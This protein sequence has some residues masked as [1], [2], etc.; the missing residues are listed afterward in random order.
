MA[1]AIA[2][3]KSDGG[4]VGLAEIVDWSERVDLVAYI[5]KAKGPRAS[6]KSWKPGRDDFGLY[7]PPAV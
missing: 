2:R 1:G 5:E 3:G 6:W 7:F 4:V